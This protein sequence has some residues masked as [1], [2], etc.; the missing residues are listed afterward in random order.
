MWIYSKVGFFSVVTHNTTGIVIRARVQKD[1]E[2]LREFSP[3]DL[4]IVETPKRDYPFRA[5]VSRSVWELIAER[6]TSEID[7][8]NFKSEVGKGDHVRAWLYSR[9]WE[10]MVSGLENERPKAKRRKVDP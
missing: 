6:L 2:A 10:I 3:I 1:L 4:E 8:P 7:Y 5:V 9:V